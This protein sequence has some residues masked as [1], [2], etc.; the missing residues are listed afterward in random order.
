MLKTLFFGTS[1][2]ALASLD[3]VA[4]RS[5]LQGV[6]TQPD[7]PAGRGQ[8]MR[9]SPV[10]AEALER[11][12]RVY[13]PTDLRAF[14]R[15]IAALSFDAFVVVSYGRILPP[16][17]LESPAMGALNVHPSLLPR[18]RGATPIQGALL[19]GDEETGVTVIAMD[20]GMDTGDVVLQESTPIYAGEDA[21]ALHDRLA[22]LGARLLG[23]A[24]A[25]GERDGVFAH[26]PQTG[27]PTLTRP[28]ARRDLDIDWS[29]P[30]ERV[31]RHVRA[32]AP[33]PAAR[34]VLGTETVKILRAHVAGGDEAAR[35][36]C[37]TGAVVI[38]TLV[39]PNRAPESGTAYA[40]RERQR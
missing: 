23:A 8:R 30:A 36:A 18:Y 2:F 31:V 3:V 14:A 24:L 22:A 11:G 10:K 37:G 33:A 5:A 32:Y 38:D 4:D 20:A 9:A 16:S 21:G 15:E 34:A 1:A 40:L 12:V 35:V 19:A 39:A 29:W 6:V 7:R 17:L 26:R 28:I 13:E 27:T 25:D